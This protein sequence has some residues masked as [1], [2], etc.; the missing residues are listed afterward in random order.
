MRNGIFFDD[1]FFFAGYE[2]V[3]SKGSEVYFLRVLDANGNLLKQLIKKRV[4]SPIQ[5][6][7]MKYYIEGYKTDKVFFLAE[8]EL[9]VVV[10]SSKS[11]E[12]VKEVQLETPNFYKKMPKDFY[13]FKKYDDPR[14]N[15]QLDIENW[16]VGYSR[17]SNCIVDNDYLVLQIRTCSD[18]L[19]NYAILLYNAGTFKLESTIFI[20]DFLLGVKDGKYYFFAKGEPG[21]DHESEESII[22]IYTIEK[23]K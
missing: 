13:I 22:N 6:Q 20:D 21:R 2:T 1:K 15:F 8:N 4:E 5:F 23:E 7:N 16:A 3:D 14:D 18:K 9:K 11:L 12:I 19:K 17:I 10:V